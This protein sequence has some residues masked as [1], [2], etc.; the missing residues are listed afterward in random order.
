MPDT[1]DRNK[2]RRTPVFEWHD[3]AAFSA[4][5]ATDPRFVADQLRR[6]AARGEPEAQLGWAHALLDG[7]G[8]PRDPAAAFR[9]FRI[10]AQSGSR[11]AINMVGRCHELGWGTPVNLPQAARAYRV[12]ADMRC[13]WAQ[14]NLASLMLHAD[15]IG[16]D[17]TE[18]LSLFVRA[19]RAGN[20]KAMNMLGQACEEG[21]RGI[22][23]PHAARRWYR[24]AARRGCFRGC[25][26][27]ARFSMSDGDVDGAVAWLE[28]SIAAGPKR[29]CVELGDYL[30]AHPDPRLRGVAADAYARAGVA[31][32]GPPPQAAL[33][34]RET[35][36]VRKPPLSRIGRG[37]RSIRRMLGTITGAG[38]PARS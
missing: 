14:F 28:R 19:A 4:R 35:P 25:F 36:A 2:A 8:T 27:T 10:A 11:D 34:A 15:E 24:R 13:A 3:A 29:F 7:H 32:E 9:W 31:P 38:K 33:P 18:A 26:N 21:W 23:K 20:A 17:R 5:L 30:A 16:R 6:A 1:G 12:A 22:S 37:R